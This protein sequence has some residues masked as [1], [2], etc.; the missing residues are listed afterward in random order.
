MEVQTRG[1]QIFIYNRVGFCSIWENIRA[2]LVEPKEPGQDK[3]S[4]DF[5]P[6]YAENLHDYIFVISEF[7]VI[8]FKT[9]I[10]RL[11]A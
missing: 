2:R 5:F 8:F 11:H 7:K 4:P 1:M 10:S 6:D 9:K 3:T